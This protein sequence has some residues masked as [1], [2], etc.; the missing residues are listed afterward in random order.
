MG[1]GALI[2]I[3]AGVAFVGLWMAVIRM[4]AAMGWDRLAA[5]FTATS[6][7]H[8]GARRFGM[9]SLYIDKSE[10]AKRL[11]SGVSYNNAITIWLDSSGLAM[12]PL[13]PFRVFH[14]LLRMAWAEVESMVSDKMLFFRVYKLQLRGDFPLLTFYGAS[15]KAIY[16]HWQTLSPATLPY[17]IRKDYR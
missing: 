11:S 17:P 14:P 8:V 10:G 1:N 13:L 5:R 12:R 7:D 9:Q 15:G 4:L 16:D 2:V 3:A 6:D